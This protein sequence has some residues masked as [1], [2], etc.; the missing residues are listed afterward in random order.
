MHFPTDDGLVKSVDGLS[1][2]LDR[3]R[4]LGI[5]GESGS[6]KS[7]TS[8]A[9]MG[10]HTRPTSEQKRP[11]AQLSGEIYLDGDELLGKTPEYVRSLRGKRMAMIFQDP[12]SAMNPYYTVGHQIIEAYRI[13]NPVNKKVARKHAI[14]LLGRVGI[15]EPEQPRRRLPAPV[16]GRDAA[17][18]HD[19]HGPVVRSRLADRRRTDH[20]SR[21]DRSSADPRPDPRPA[22]PN[23]IPPSC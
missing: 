4:T 16:L 8:L 18:G 14:D 1:F 2:A 11:G 10:L 15:P 19:R 3:G 20:R 7:V 9:I 5:V 21:R 22:D 12:L 6:G 17:A 23:S 13:H